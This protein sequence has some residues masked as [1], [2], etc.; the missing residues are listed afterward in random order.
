MGSGKSPNEA[1]HSKPPA[2]VL[3]SG[4][5]VS[6][7]GAATVLQVVLNLGVNQHI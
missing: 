7:A 1:D 5:P 6:H 4:L 2:S 3:T